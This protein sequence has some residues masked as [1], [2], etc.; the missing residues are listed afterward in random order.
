MAL[1]RIMIRH[2]LE[3]MALGKQIPSGLLAFMK[4]QPLRIKAKMSMQFIMPKP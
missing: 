1:I 3:M 2:L 4:A